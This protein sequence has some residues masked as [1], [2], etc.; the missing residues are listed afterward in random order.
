MHFIDYLKIELENQIEERVVTLNNYC[1]DFFQ[2]LWVKHANGRLSLQ[3]VSHIMWS[4]MW[5]KSLASGIPLVSLCN[6][7]NSTHIVQLKIRPQHFQT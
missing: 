7:W 2:T 4:S 3:V 5:Q 1:L 6:A